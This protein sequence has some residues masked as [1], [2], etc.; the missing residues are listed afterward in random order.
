MT[1]PYILG[2]SVAEFNEPSTTFLYALRRTEDGDLYL[3][4]VNENDKSNVNLFGE[5]IPSQFADYALGDDFFEGRGED[6]VLDYTTADVKYEQWKFVN[7]EQTYY[8]DSDGYFTLDTSNLQ[9]SEIED[10]Q[11]PAGHQQ[12]FTISGENY[13]I[14]LFDKLIEM[15]WNGLSSVALTISGNIGSTHPRKAALSIDKLFKNGLTI[16]NNGNIVGCNGNLQNDPVVNRNFGIAISIEVPVTEFTNNG[17]IKA[18]VFN[19][20]Y[21]NAFRGWTNITTWDNNGTWIGYDD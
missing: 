20:Q 3:L 2:K 9:L 18:G 8:I 12:S 1:T 6:H 19:S 4:K 16:I 10:I 17:L 14:N 11:I 21:A 5:T 15:G 7:S 13:N